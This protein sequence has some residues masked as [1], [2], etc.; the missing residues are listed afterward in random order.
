MNNHQKAPASKNASKT[1]QLHHDGITPSVNPFHKQRKAAVVIDLE[2]MK[3]V[4]SSGILKSE[5][6]CEISEL[7]HD[8]IASPINPIK[9]AFY[10]LQ[11]YTRELLCRQYHGEMASFNMKN[12]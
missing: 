10:G 6:A 8:G 5:S 1:S 11:Q 4:K 3:I 9:H 7:H 2:A 12:C